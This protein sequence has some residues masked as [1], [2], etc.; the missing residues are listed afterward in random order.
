MVLLE[1]SVVIVSE[2][3]DLL[4]ADTEALVNTVN[5]VGVM[6]KG[7][8]LQFKR[9]FPDMYKSYRAAA[10]RGDVQL[11]RVHVWETGLL[12]NPRFIINFPTKGH[13][14]QNSVLADVEEG[15]ADLARVVEELGIRSI[16]IPPLGCGNG[17]LEW[18]AVEPLIR[19]AFAELPDV[20]VHIYAPQGAPAAATLAVGTTRP[21]MTPGRAALVEVIRRYSAQAFTA[22]GPIEVQKLMYFLQVAGEPLRLQFDASHYGPYADNLRHVLA[23]VEG[24]YLVGYGDGSKAVRA[25]ESLRLLPGAVEEAQ[26]ALHEATD[27]QARIGRVLRLA[28]GFESAYGLELLATIHWIAALS[29]DPDLDQITREVGSWSA[30]KE[31]IFT[32]AH[33][34]AALRAMTE[35]AWLRTPQT[36]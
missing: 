35:H 12:A 23:A 17:G 24:H 22:P 7:I 14:R 19:D 16:A 32:R 4:R 29:G 31:R 27:T 18:C 30:R 15:L 11:G 34:E 5:T 20:T 28:E 13:W 8:A 33:I 10:K 26:M 21:A 6:G 36:V 9:T 2:H 3:G 25:S 1:G